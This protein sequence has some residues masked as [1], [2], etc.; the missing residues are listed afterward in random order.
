MFSLDVPLGG[1]NV[2]IVLKLD[3]TWDE[4]Y[5]HLEDEGTQPLVAN[6]K[7]SVSVSTYLSLPY[8]VMLNDSFLWEILKTVK[9]M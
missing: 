5:L 3:M 4:K 9:L 7:T 8:T 1:S 6:L 2:V